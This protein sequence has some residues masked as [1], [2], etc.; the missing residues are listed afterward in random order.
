MPI[1]K[2]RVSTEAH[3]GREGREYDTPDSWRVHLGTDSNNRAKLSPPVDSF[4]EA[5]QVPPHGG[6]LLFGRLSVVVRV[7]AHLAETIFEEV[8]SVSRSL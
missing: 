3:N 7:V 5:A 8:A 1:R 2:T 6:L 4:N